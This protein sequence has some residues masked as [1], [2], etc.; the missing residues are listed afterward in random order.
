MQEQWDQRL[1]FSIP[2]RKVITVLP[3][4]DSSLLIIHHKFDYTAIRLSSPD[5]QL[6][7]LG[8][9]PALSDKFQIFTPN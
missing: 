6:L 2:I 5:S 3:L 1:T 8:S 4:S 9:L 7:A